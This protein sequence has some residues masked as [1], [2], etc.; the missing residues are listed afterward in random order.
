M[1]KGNLGFLKS[2]LHRSLYKPL[3]FDFVS[4]K[5]AGTHELN[6]N[7]AFSENKATFLTMLGVYI[8]LTH[9]K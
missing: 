2:I 8:L 9:G 3:D 6:T 7:L 5:K 4:L 1:V